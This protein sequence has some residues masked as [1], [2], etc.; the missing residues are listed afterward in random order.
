MHILMFNVSFRV[1]S[2]SMFAEGHALGASNK[3]N[4]TDVHCCMCSYGSGGI[5][6]LASVLPQARP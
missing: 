1:I 4:E 3:R 5:S 6:G 2:I